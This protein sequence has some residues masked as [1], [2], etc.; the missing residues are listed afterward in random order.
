[1]Y[2]YSPNYFH[3]IEIDIIV[4]IVLIICSKLFNHSI[5]KSRVV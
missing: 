4:Y 3:Y 2:K 1:M 5:N